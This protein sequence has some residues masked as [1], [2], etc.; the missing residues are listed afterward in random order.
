[1]QYGWEKRI[2]RGNL[3]EAMED[4]DGLLPKNVRV[5]GVVVAHMDN[6]EGAFIPHKLF[7]PEGMVEADIMLDAGGDI[8][9]LRIEALK[10]AGLTHKPRLTGEDKDPLGR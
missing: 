8:D 3:T 1:M 5:I 4:M 7:K 10:A 6:V 9:R 2:N